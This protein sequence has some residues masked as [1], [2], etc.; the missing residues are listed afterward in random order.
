MSTAIR[1]P[2]TPESDTSPYIV[3][4]K[5]F[6]KTVNQWTDARVYEYRNAVP[7]LAKRLQAER[8][9]DRRG[10]IRSSRFTC[11]DFALRMLVQFAASNGLPLKLTT[12]VRTYRNT[13][14]YG[15]AEH[16]KHDA[17]MY[18]FSDMVG[19]TYGA[20]DMQ[21]AGS[22]TMR[23]DSAED[24]MPGDILALAHDLKGA[25]TGGI[26][27][28]VQM[29]ASR[30][31]TSIEIF[32]GNSD[33]TIHRPITW[34]NR[35]LGRN[36]ADPQQSAYAGRPIETGHFTRSASGWDYQN[37]VTGSRRNNYLQFFELYRWNF[38]EFNR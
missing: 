24:L 37:H 12:G 4:L 31:E 23:V 7:Q 32:Q 11:E 20:P 26:A 38:M 15:R 28:H 27:H 10:N 14:V 33:A 30:S 34:F 29:V 5:V 17:T 13:E 36:A 8:Y 35:L 1:V 16:E 2:L 19:L 9:W 25:N 21:R 18:G 22:N 6:W 3:K